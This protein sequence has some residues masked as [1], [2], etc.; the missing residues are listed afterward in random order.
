MLAGAV[1]PD[2]L[3]A[4]FFPSRDQVRPDT[5]SPGSFGPARV[6]FLRRSMKAS[7]C[8]PATFQTRAAFAPESSSAKVASSASS[9]AATTSM[10]PGEPSRAIETR[11]RAIRSRS[12]FEDIQTTFPSGE[13]NPVYVPGP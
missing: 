7:S 4:S 3:M 6:S 11:A 12:P 1:A 13:N 10:G 2:T 9:R 5:M 8:R